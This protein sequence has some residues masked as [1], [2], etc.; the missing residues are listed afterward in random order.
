MTIDSSQVVVLCVMFP[1]VGM[2]SPGRTRRISF[3]CSR[4]R[5]ISSSMTGVTLIVG[6]ELE[7]S[8]EVVVSRTATRVAVFGQRCDN[9]ERALLVAELALHSRYFPNMTKVIRSADV[10]KV[11]IKRL[12]HST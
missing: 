8:F 11:F 2:V 1:S 12:T 4:T 3:N 7:I 6:L 10:S 9:L 5:G